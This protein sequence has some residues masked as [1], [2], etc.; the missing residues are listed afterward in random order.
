MR[1]K[2]AFFSNLGP[3]KT[4][5][6]RVLVPAEDDSTF[7][8]AAIADG[9]GGAPGGEQAAALALRAAARAKS[10]PD[11]LPK[12]FSIALR[13]FRKQ[14]LREPELGKMGTTLSIALLV[15]RMA[16]IAHVGDTRIYHLRGQGLNNLTEDQT[17]V[18]TLLRRGVL[19]KSQA[20]RYPRR[21]VL[22]S[23]LSPS[24]DYEIF[25]SSARLE[26][27]D[28]LLLLTDGVYTRV[29]RRNIANASLASER[30]ETFVAAVE[31]LTIDAEP[32]DNFTA[33]GLEILS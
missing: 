13:A 25:R 33:L 15:D 6:D 12:V 16:Y 4:N 14:A 21:G 9:I 2:C 1:V 29:P 24:G 3:R 19:R 28:R 31:R 17:E 22:L 20:A 10:D 18:A 7:L 23:A 27:G 11:E 8:I 26:V 5:Q 30:V 32:S